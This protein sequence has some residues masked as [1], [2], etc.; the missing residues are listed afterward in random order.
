MSEATTLQGYDEFIAQL[1]ALREHN[2]TVVFDYEDPR[3]NKEA[4]SH[5]YKLRQTKAAV[6][7][8][9]KR[10]KEEHLAAGRAID[11]SA[12]QIIGEVQG[13]IEVHE[14]PLKAIEAREAERVAKL[15]A[16]LEAIPMEGPRE[17]SSADL[18]ALL[19]KVGAVEL[20]E[21]WQ[22][23]LE[24]AALRKDAAQRSL[25]GELE[26]ARKREAEAAELARLRAEQEAQRQR[27][28]EE[29]REREE[30][31]RL[32][33]A[34]EKAR[35]EAE[36][37]AKAEAD[38]AL[39]EAQRREQAAVERAKADVEKARQRLENERREAEARELKLKLA[40][41]QAEKARL[42]EKAREQ[43]AREAEAAEAERRRADEAHRARVLGEVA[44][45]LLQAAPALGEDGAAEVAK[46]LANGYIP[47]T[48]VR[49]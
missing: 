39:A 25:H 17:A 38:A 37:K 12:K 45:A 1:Q 32:A 11:E 15:Q 5:I 18:E 31:R 27:E 8:R 30:A 7:K 20:D 26:A 42:Q 22:E 28:A 41:E 49:F 13:M 35:Q 3:G 4:R 24:D 47:H 29:A 34:A 21:S 40:A 23:F 9:R 2:E 48:T 46:L 33:E 44:A 36:A 19:A 16:R 14:E 6:E 10:L 43:A